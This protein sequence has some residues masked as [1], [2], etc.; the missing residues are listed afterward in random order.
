M[1]LEAILF[2]KDGT[3]VDFDRTWGPAAYAVMRT[4]ADGDEGAFARL[5]EVSMFDLEGRKFGPDSPLLAGSSAVYG[6]LWAKAIGV[7]D[8]PRLCARM[9]DLFRNAALETLAPL[10]DLPALAGGLHARGLKLGIASNDAE[11][12]VRAQAARLGLTDLMCFMAGYDS[13][14]G[15]KPLPGMVTAFA[16][17]CGV[18]PGRVAMVGDTMHDIHAAKAAGAVAVGVLTGPAQHGELLQHADHV[19]EHVQDLPALI[20]R[21]RAAA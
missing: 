17:H 11:A 20:D 12:S 3:L 2:D 6:P 9:D 21:L 5:V 19:I 4:L 8:V 15:G 13:G 18:A 7:S 10:C 16:D 14:H 1:T